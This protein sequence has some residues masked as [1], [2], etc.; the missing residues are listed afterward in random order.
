MS[1]LHIGSVLETAVNMASQEICLQKT[2]GIILQRACLFCQCF[3]FFFFTPSKAA[4]AVS[5]WTLDLENGVLWKSVWRY[6]VYMGGIYV[7]AVMETNGAL[8]EVPRTWQWHMETILIH[9][10][11]LVTVKSR[12][13]IQTKQKEYGRVS[14]NQPQS[15][16][17]A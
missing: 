17:V 3:R 5:G 9:Q 2:R 11:S 10:I 8:E 7:K 12:L 1:H 13:S 16:A 15:F 6:T 14:G 4:D